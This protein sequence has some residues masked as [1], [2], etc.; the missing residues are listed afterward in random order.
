MC[1]CSHAAVFHDN[2]P[3]CV[4]RFKGTLYIYWTVNSAIVWKTIATESGG[5]GIDTGDITCV[6][7]KWWIAFFHMSNT[8]QCLR[9]IFQFCHQLSTNGVGYKCLSIKEVYIYGQ[10]IHVGLADFTSITPM[11]WNSFTASYPWE[12]CRAYSA[13]A[14][15]IHTT[16]FRST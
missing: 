5:N 12:E 1:I 7:G 10:D 15:H 4:H 13:K 9:N 2:I 8:D 6:T 11:Y 16:N 3:V 14:M